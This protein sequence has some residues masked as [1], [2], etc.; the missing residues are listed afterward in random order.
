MSLPEY[1]TPRVLH[2]GVIEPGTEKNISYVAKLASEKTGTLQ[3]ALIARYTYEWN[4]QKRAG[5]TRSNEYSIIVEYGE[6]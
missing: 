1:S 6:E 4:G 5:E 3:G 2:V